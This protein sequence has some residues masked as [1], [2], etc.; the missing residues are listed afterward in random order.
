MLL[1]DASISQ[2]PVDY[3]IY[4]G[5]SIH[6]PERGAISPK[7]KHAVLSHR[8]SFHFHLSI[9]AASSHREEVWI[10]S[11]LPF[12]CSLLNDSSCHYGDFHL[13]QRCWFTKRPANSRNPNPWKKNE[14][15]TVSQAGAQYGKGFLNIGHLVQKKFF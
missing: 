11:K 3:S 6:M 4:L 1:L 12:S 9:R 14:I 5:Y 10:F 15:H 7:W 8:F 2:C 13:S